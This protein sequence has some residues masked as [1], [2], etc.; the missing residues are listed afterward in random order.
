MQLTYQYPL[1]CSYMPIFFFVQH[2]NDLSFAIDL[3]DT[4]KN[5]E[6]IF[7]QL[8]DMNQLPDSIAELLGFE[9]NDGAAA[10]VANVNSSSEATPVDV[11]PNNSTPSTPEK[12]RASTV[13]TSQKDVMHDDSRLVEMT[14]KQNLRKSPT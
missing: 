2:I 9:L 8:K 3:E 11:T 10:A 14:S 4:L 6:G 1:Y 12:Q 5:A 13:V 7:L